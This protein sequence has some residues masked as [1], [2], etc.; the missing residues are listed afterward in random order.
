ML[1]VNG[2]LAI[3]KEVQTQYG[4]EIRSLHTTLQNTFY[5]W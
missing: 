2:L 1:L 5:W 4:T 3:N